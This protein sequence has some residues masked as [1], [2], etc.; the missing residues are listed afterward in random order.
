MY[1]FIIRFIACFIVDKQQRRNFRK[2]HCYHKNGINIAMITD[3][4]YVMPT[5][6]C[7]Q[8][9]KNNCSGKL[10]I[11]VFVN[12]VSPKNINSLKSVSSKSCDI[13][14]YNCED[15]IN[16]YLT[17]DVNRHVSVTAIIKFFLPTMLNYLDKILYLDS[18]ILVKGDLTIL[19]KTNIS[20]KYAAVVKD[21]LCIK[22]HQYMDSIGIKNQYYFNSGVMLLN[23]T[24]MREN[25]ITKKLIDYRMNVKQHFI[26]QDAFNA[27][28]GDNVIYMSYKY[29]FL[30]YYMT[31]MTRKQLTDF[32]EEEIPDCFWK[33]Y[34]S[35]IILHLGGAEKPWWQD[36]G[37]LSNLYKKYY[38][39]MLHNLNKKSIKNV[40][41]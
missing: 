6:V 10:N 24:K 19:Y 35:S 26:D 41:R 23:L 14:I 36:M 12:N 38:I 15:I 4:N 7:I 33:I 25:N 2:K 40:K 11:H 16:K 31:V 8:S 29:N 32:F 5:L 13:I 39:D 27:I 3:D 17:I 20:N 28:I 34:E 22:N 37:Y 18:D 9:I 30:P 1:N 21:V